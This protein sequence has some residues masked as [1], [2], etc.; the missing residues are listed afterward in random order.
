[1]KT[2]VITDSASYLDRNVAAKYHILVLPIT[3]IFGQQQYQDGVTITSKAFLEKLANNDQLPT[4]AQVTMGQM[5]TAFDQL[6]DQGFDEVIC[7]NLSSGITSFYENL[8]A[9]SRQVTNI[10]VFP[11]DSKIASAGEADLALLAGKLALAGENAATIL[12]KLKQLRDSIHVCLVVD[13]LSHLQRTGR[14]S[15]TSAF[16]GNLLKIKPMLTFDQAGKIV[17]LAKDRTLRQS[18]EHIVRF[19]SESQ[20]DFN[21]PMRISVVDAN[22]PEQSQAWVR[23]FHEQFPNAAISTDQISPAITVHTGEKAMGVVWDIDWQSLV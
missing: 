14:I 10:K 21:L 1:M 6:S 15:N 16:F 17:P 22:N 18:L 3:V 23:R 13:S 8:V 19:I 11:F 4:T 2:A 9:Y 12:P 5:Q 7:V 20:A